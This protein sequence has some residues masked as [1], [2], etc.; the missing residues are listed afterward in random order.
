MNQNFIPDD[1]RSVHLIAVCGTAMGAL[2]AALKDM[3]L[4]VTGS[5]AGVYPP[6]STYLACRGIA[7]TEGFSAKNLAHAPDLVVVG[8]AVK[9]DN[10][11]AA[12]VFEMGLAFCSMPQAINHFLVGDKQA[13]VITGTHGKTTTASL[14]AWLLHSAGL[15]PSFMIGGIL[16]NF[17]ANYRVGRGPYVVLEGD[18]YDTA[19]FD[20][21]AKFL[22]YPPAVA[23]LT[24]V[25][26]DHA[27]IFNDLD[28]I[29]A[30]FD[31]FLSNIADKSLLIACDGDSNIDS[32]LPNTHCRIE[33]YGHGEQAAWQIGE[34]A[35]DPPWS[36]FA[37]KHNGRMFG[38]FQMRLIGAHNR[39]NALS[40]VAVA[41]NLGLCPQAIAAGLETFAGVKRRQEIRGV[42]N[43]VTVIDDFAHHPTAVRETVGAVKAFYPENRLIAVFEP[44]TNTS[45]RR[46]FQQTYSDAF[47]GAD[48]VCIRKPPLL[49]KIAEGQRFSSEKLVADLKSRGF[50]AHYFDETAAIIDFVAASARPGDIVLVMSNGGF[51]NIHER[52]LARLQV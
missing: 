52:L 30:V 29:V 20:K 21:G 47:A 36:R 19:F 12:A 8:N 13:I 38:R 51:D 50:D 39:L 49:D 18:E 15:E 9:R 1:V 5:D 17:N 42:E 16:G 7:V 35:V 28:H 11:E 37:V 24:S 6:M 3:G 43:G 41:A 2:A 25:E 23:V 40:A 14:V 34:T 31:R 32:L 10:P 33:R 44:R 4:S 22:H 48:T 27:D 45:M 26:F 46:V